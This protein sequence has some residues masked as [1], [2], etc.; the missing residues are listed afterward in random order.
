MNETKKN[1][2]I[3]WEWLNS[4]K[5]VEKKGVTRHIELKTPI[6]IKINGR[7]NKGV[8][9]KSGISK[10]EDAEILE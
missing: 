3:D 8:I 7:E 10:P 1:G 4:Q 6:T 9:I 2:F 5:I